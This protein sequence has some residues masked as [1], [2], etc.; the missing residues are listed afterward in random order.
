MI[1]LSVILSQGYSSCSK[2]YRIA[3][4]NGIVGGKAV[5]KIRAVVDVNIPCIVFYG[6]AGVL[7][8]G[9]KSVDAGY[10][11]G[12]VLKRFGVERYF[13]VFVKLYEQI[14]D[15]GGAANTRSSV[16]RI[17]SVTVLRPFFSSATLTITFI[18]MGST[19]LQADSAMTDPSMSKA[20]TS[21]RIF[22][23]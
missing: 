3:G 2:G 14:A 4:G 5:L 17:V 7:L 10:L 12:F 9:R 13:A 15:G 22:F 20:R 18:F 11:Y 6:V 16:S 21:D 1:R 8:L 23:H 19:L